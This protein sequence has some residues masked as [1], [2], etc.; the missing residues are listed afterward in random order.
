MR[1]TY[2]VISDMRVKK[3]NNKK[4][5]NFQSPDVNVEMFE[6]ISVSC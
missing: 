6:N 1:E 4:E 3:N 2:P 5:K